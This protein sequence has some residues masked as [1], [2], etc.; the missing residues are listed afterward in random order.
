M[1]TCKT[2]W[3]NIDKKLMFCSVDCA[4]EQTEKDE[5]DE[6]DEKSIDK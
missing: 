5:K 2:C 3:L 4:V 6:K 1:N